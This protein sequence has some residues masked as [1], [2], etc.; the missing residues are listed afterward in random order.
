M[1]KNLSSHGVRFKSKWPLLP[2]FLRNRW[3]MPK[4]RYTH[5]L[6]LAFFSYQTLLSLEPTPQHA[7]SLPRAKKHGKL[8]QGTNHHL[9]SDRHRR[10]RGGNQVGEI[11]RFGRL[12]M[13]FHLIFHEIMQNKFSLWKPLTKGNLQLPSAAWRAS[14]ISTGP[15]NVAPGSHSAKSV[16]S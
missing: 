6:L 8:R 4:R 2:W 9:G 13:K 3:I 1:R 7:S 12:R 5:I 10:V 16:S 14:G 11:L 15:R